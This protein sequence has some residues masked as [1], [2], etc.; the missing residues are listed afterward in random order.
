MKKLIKLL[1]IASLFLPLTVL[2]APPYSFTSTL[3][4][5]NS[6][7]DVGSTT[8][9]AYRNIVAQWFTATSTKA[10]LFPYASTTA[11][12]S[13]NAWFTGNV[14]IGTTSPYSILSISNTR[15]TPLNTSLLTI[16]STTNGLSTTTLLTI[17]AN[18]NTGIR[19]TNPRGYLD[20]GA[21]NVNGFGESIPAY[22][23]AVNDQSSG[24]GAGLL[25]SNS[26]T[27]SGTSSIIFKSPT[28]GDVRPFSSG[29]IISGFN[30]S[31]YTGTYLTLGSAAGANRYNNELTLKNGRVGIGTTSPESLL[32]VEGLA[33]FGTESAAT[34]QVKVK[35]GA[36]GQPMIT[37][38][39][40]SGVTVQY[41]WALAAGGLSFTD[42]V[43]G[44]GTANLFGDSSS[45]DL[46][47]G[48]RGKVVSDAARPSLLSGTTYNT[49][50]GSDTSAGN[51]VIQGG[52]GLGA[53]T[54]GDIQFKTGTTLSSGTTLQ[55]GTIR[56]TIKSTTGNFGVGTTSPYKKLSVA[57]DVVMDSFNATSTTAT[58]TIA[59]A[60]KYGRAGTVTLGTSGTPGTETVNVPIDNNSVIFLTQQNCVSCGTVWVDATTTS[61]FTIISSGGA[62]LSTI[63]WM[64]IQK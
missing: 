47:L 12:S 32:D 21:V 20:V 57:G 30:T 62:D 43:S 3:L 29:Q 36:S 52:L 51:M 34:A 54:P 27:V 11:I 14:G 9:S 26:G 35:G 55:T 18:G 25:V 8:L 60:L 28:T 19:N 15:N 56:A 50:A 39:R 45:N 61:S 48:L 23:L 33:T 63:G 44:A 58:S 40:T 31:G 64:V 5:N 6:L 10:S 17:L 37:L 59:G 53:G 16:A 2:G 49:S 1:L 13:G 41:S 24:G 38:I 4:P 7:T 46:Y 42:D 22:R